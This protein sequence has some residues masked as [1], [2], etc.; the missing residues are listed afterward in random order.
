M[1]EEAEGG[2]SSEDYGEHSTHTRHDHPYCLGASTILSS[3]RMFAVLSAAAAQEEGATLVPHTLH[4]ATAFGNS[5]ILHDVDIYAAELMRMYDRICAAIYWY[6]EERRRGHGSRAC[7]PHGYGSLWERAWKSNW[8]TSHRTQARNSTLEHAC[9]SR[10]I[11]GLQC[12]CPS[13]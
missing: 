12:I 11:S 6:S 3:R 7:H 2:D 9:R 10:I 8:T 13:S 1:S 4:E 5:T